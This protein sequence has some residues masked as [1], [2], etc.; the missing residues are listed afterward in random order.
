MTGVFMIRGVSKP[1]T[2]LLTVDPRRAE[3][4]REIKGTMSFNRK[5]YGM[6]G[7]IPFVRISDHV[8]VAIDLKVKRV[9]GPPVA[10][11]P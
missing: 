11:K 1:Q 4:V 8:E 10:L 7:G 9:S 2:L 3:L 6:N 5:D